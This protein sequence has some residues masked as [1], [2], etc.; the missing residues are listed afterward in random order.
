VPL[1]DA[2]LLPTDIVVNGAN[3][4]F[5]VE[6]AGTYLISYEI[7]ASA[8][9]LINASVLLNGTAIPASVE[10]PIISVSAL[11]NQTLITLAAGDTL[12]LQ[13][14]S[15]LPDTLTLASGNGASL[16]IMRVS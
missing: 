16:L 10:A 13:V 1:P 6:T 8:A 5:T 4:T 3:D 2:Q 9:L 12:S 11:N 14:L 15:A 7:L